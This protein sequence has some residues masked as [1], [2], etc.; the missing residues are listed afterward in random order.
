MNLYFH[1]VVIRPLIGHATDK[2]VPQ[3]L[4]DSIVLT[5]DD[6]RPNSGA[7]ADERIVGAHVTMDLCQLSSGPYAARAYRQCRRSNQSRTTR[8]ARFHHRFFWLHRWFRG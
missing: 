2:L 3:Y 7:E 1:V 6:M 4:K 5:N 8:S